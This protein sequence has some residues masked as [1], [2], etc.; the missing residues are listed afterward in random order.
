VRSSRHAAKLHP[1]FAELHPAFAE[2]HP[3]F[4]KLP[5][6]FADF[7]PGW[8]AHRTASSD[9]NAVVARLHTEPSGSRTAF[10]NVNTAAATSKTT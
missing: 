7:P 2:L 4:A 6:A 8:G 5:P 1:A 9:Q 10:A 3:A